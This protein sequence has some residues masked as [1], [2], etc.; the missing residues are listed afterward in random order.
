V[1][2]YG[3]TICLREGDDVEREYRKHHEAVWPEVVRSLHAVGVIGL[4]IFLHGRQL[5]MVLDTV[6]DFD[7]ERDFARHV[8]S[9]AKCAEWETLMKAHQE[10]PPGAA[11]GAWWAQ[12]ECVCHLPAPSEGTPT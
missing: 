7:P 6:D 8:A 12:M 4:D 10:P 3:L 2:R 1:K 9:S 5:F 11:P